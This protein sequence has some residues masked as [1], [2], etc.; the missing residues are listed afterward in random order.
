MNCVTRFGEHF[1][2]FGKMEYVGLFFEVRFQRNF[3]VWKNYDV[4]GIGPATN[5]TI[6]SI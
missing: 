6:F 5:S 3:A 1:G 4:K 2:N